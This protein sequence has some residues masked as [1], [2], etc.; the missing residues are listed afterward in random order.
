MI[1][2]IAAWLARSMVPSVLGRRAEARDAASRARDLAAAKGE[3]NVTR[4]AEALL[5]AAG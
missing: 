4:R 1:D 2:T 3:V 5:R